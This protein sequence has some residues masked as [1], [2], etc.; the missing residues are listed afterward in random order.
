MWLKITL[1][2][3]LSNSTR[4]IF[5][6]YNVIDFKILEI[7]NTEWHDIGYREISVW[8]IAH[9]KK[10]YLKYEED[11]IYSSLNIKMFFYFH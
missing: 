2:K 5:K 3:Y 8:E 4:K 1:E 6:I 10:K 11:V 7:K 9:I